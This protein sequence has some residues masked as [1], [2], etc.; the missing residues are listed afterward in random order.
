[1]RGNR[2]LNIGACDGIRT[3]TGRRLR[4]LSLPDWSTQ[5][6]DAGVGIAP[7]YWAYETRQDLSPVEP[8]LKVG[9]LTRNRTRT[10]GVQNRHATTIIIRAKQTRAPRRYRNVDKR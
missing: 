8:A 2:L 1:M 9:A 3:H 5:A 10:S 4:T 6:L 7:T